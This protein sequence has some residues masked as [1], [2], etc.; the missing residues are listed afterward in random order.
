M[1]KTITAADLIREVR[2]IAAERPD[3]AYADQ[4]GGDGTCSYFG[5][6]TSD[7]T[8]Q[9]C[10]IGQAFKRLGYEPE[11]LRFGE[12]NEGQNPNINTVIQTWSIPASTPESMW[13]G[14]VQRKQD[15]GDNWGTAVANADDWARLCGIEVV[16]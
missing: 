10:I 14:R 8:G 6:S 3:F 9:P 1:T 5:R 13:L 15:H 12:L 11:G 16:G 4:P 7:H 2:I